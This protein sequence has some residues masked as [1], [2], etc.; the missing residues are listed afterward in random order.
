MKKISN[1]L[2]MV[3]PVC[4]LAT[5]GLLIIDSLKGPGA[6]VKHFLIDGKLLWAM[7]LVLMALLTST[8]SKALNLL[9]KLNLFVL[10]PVC[11]IYLI[12]VGLEAAHYPNFVLSA[13]GIHLDALIY[14]PVFSA[15]LFLVQKIIN[16][17]PKIFLRS[18]NDYVLLI[19]IALTTYFALWNLGSVLNSAF[20]NDSYILAHL[21]DS[22]D[23]K[24]YFQ[25]GD[26]YRFMSF[27]K[28]NTP[29]DAK[30]IIPP[31]MDPW[32]ARTG[33]IQLVRAFLYPRE[34][35][36]FN[37]VVLDSKFLT[38]GT[39]IFVS[40]GDRDCGRSDCHGW[41]KQEIRAKK[42]IYKDPDSNG[43]IESK[44]NFFYKKDDGKYVYG[45][46]KI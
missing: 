46:I 33:D 2:N 44:D 8:K 42:I 26:F 9:L 43:V 25:W 30:I 45:L 3:I 40:W 31:E 18:F 15:S 41:P 35:I 7:D 17:F 14:L 11:I 16:E 10:I 24:M 39:F 19:T 5:Y 28:N 27:V 34:I 29:D 6:A 32:L 20:I 37:T 38:R 1:L 36:Q 12:F 4:I 22:Y 21:N 23:Q 13:Y